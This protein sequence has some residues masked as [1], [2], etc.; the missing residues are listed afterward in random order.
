MLKW[1]RGGGED[2]SGGN[3]VSLLAPELPRLA[4][5]SH[6]LLNTGSRYDLAIPMQHLKG[7][8]SLTEE[9]WGTWF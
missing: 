6:L 1:G 9:F 2:W 7:N 8:P 4:M 3:S 5:H